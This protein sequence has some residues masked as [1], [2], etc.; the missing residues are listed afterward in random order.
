MLVST[1]LLFLLVRHLLLVAMHLLLVD[2]TAEEKLLHESVRHKI[3]SVSLSSAHAAVTFPWRLRLHNPSADCCNTKTAAGSWCGFSGAM[4][5]TAS[6]FHSGSPLRLCLQVP[7][8]CFQIAVA[9][10]FGDVNGAQL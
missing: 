10:G 3:L 1:S 8:R 6:G 5:I 9:L 7:S 2:Q 4:K